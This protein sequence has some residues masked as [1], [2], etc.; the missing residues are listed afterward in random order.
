[1]L[2]KALGSS[3]DP[4]GLPETFSAFSGQDCTDSCAGLKEWELLLGKAR[5]RCGLDINLDCCSRL[6]CFSLLHI[7]KQSPERSQAG[8]SL[9]ERSSCAQGT[10]VRVLTTQGTF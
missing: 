9:S 8:G 2:G 7:Q 4:S 6:P 3:Y 5:S 1:M 10:H